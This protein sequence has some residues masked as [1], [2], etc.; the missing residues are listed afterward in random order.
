MKNIKPYLKKKISRHKGALIA[1][2][3]VGSSL[4]AA[5]YCGKANGHLNIDLHLIAKGEKLMHVASE[6]INL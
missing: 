2:P 4:A 6:P 3:I 5:Y 1:L